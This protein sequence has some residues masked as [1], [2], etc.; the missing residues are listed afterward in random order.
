[1][2]SL[3]QEA[4]LLAPQLN[5][6]H[7]PLLFWPNSNLADSI[8]PGPW[9]RSAL[10]R[11]DYVVSR[12][13][14]GCQTIPLRKKKK[15][16]IFNSLESDVF[17]SPIY[18]THETSLT[19]GATFHAILCQ[20]FMFRNIIWAVC[21]TKGCTT[22]QQPKYHQAAPEN[23]WLIAGD[24]FDTISE[25]VLQLQGLHWNYLCL[26]LLLPGPCVKSTPRG[27]QVHLAIHIACFV[28]KIF[29]ICLSP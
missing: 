29:L 19:I 10:L 3:A 27:S 15:K 14:R 28:Q 23:S 4:G 2:S 12:S 13:H 26:Y 24:C 22:T 11:V 21:P 5:L 25:L 8:S 18:G 17:P 9:A 7:S 6:L 20:L 16:H 1:M